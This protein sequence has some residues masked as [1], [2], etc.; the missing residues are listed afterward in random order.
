MYNIPLLVFNTIIIEQVHLPVSL[1]DYSIVSQKRF[2]TISQ[3]YTV[4]SGDDQ[5]DH[6]PMLCYL[7]T[8]INNL[9]SENAIFGKPYVL[10]K[11][12]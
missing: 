1:F 10:N 4:D 2:D 7:S 11:S 12:H 8:D 6:L 5:S 9:Y 3:Y